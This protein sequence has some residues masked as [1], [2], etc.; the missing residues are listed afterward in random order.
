MPFVKKAEKLKRGIRE[1]VLLPALKRHLKPGKGL[2]FPNQ[3]GEYMTE[4]QYTR[5]WDDFLCKVRVT[6]LLREKRLVQ[7]DSALYAARLRYNI[8]LV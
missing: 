5:L 8:V 1:V 6:G 4:S 3:N 2:V 7:A